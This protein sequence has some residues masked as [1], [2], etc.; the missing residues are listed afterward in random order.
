MNVL[1]YSIPQMFD[2]IRSGK[3]ERE[4]RAILRYVHT[5]KQSVINRAR[6][7]IIDLIVIVCAR[8]NY[9]HKRVYLATRLKY[10]LALSDT[11]K[12]MRGNKWVFCFIESIRNPGE[13]ST[14]H[15]SISVNLNCCHLANFFMNW[16][17]HFLIFHSKVKK[18]KKKSYRN[19][20][21]FFI[22]RVSSCDV[23]GH[24][25][26][27][28]SC[29]L[30][31]QRNPWCLAVQWQDLSYSAS[32]FTCIVWTTDNQIFAL[33]VDYLLFLHSTNLF[34]LHFCLFLEVLGQHPYLNIHDVSVRITG[35]VFR[36]GLA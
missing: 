22:H 17:Y 2:W 36:V 20:Q 6:W 29:L 12:A 11:F 14:N 19:K 1:L 35:H 10:L 33:Y 28:I 8:E 18:R 15:Y 30:W 25:A 4:I 5:T 31:E 24:T 21:P 16:R 23:L 13:Y 3:W 34:R 9:N 26:G 7:Q 32:C 27:T